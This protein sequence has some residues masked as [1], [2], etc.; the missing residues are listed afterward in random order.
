MQ[1][2]EGT[3]EIAQGYRAIIVDKGTKVQ[4]IKRKATY[5][6]CDRCRDCKHLLHGKYLFSPNQWWESYA[7]EKKPKKVAGKDCFYWAYSNAK[8]CEM[9][10]KREE[11]HE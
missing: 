9:F 3:Y 2:Q 8:A 10:D 6:K 4:I 11:S 7:C 5:A 1:L